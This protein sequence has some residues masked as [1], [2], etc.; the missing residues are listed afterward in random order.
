[1]KLYVQAKNIQPI[2]QTIKLCKN[3]KF[4]KQKEIFGDNKSLNE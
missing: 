2:L 3:L 4:L 1:M